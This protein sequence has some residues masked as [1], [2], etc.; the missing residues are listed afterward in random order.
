MRPGEALIA[1]SVAVVAPLFGAEDPR[2]FNLDFV[3]RYGEHRQQLTLKALHDLAGSSFDQPPAP[4]DDRYAHTVPAAGYYLT[5]L[6]RSRGY[7]AVLAKGDSDSQLA[8]IA[9]ASPRVVCISSTMLFSAASLRHLVRRVRRHL[10]GV[11]I[12]VG[13]IQVWKSYRW[14]EMSRDGLRVDDASVREQRHWSIFP[15]HRSDIEVDVFVVSPHG[16]DLLQ[17]VLRELERGESADLESIENLALPDGDGRF[18]FTRRIEER[19][20]YDHDFTRW[21]LIDE[22]PAR[23]P[24]RSSVGCPNRCAYCDFCVVYPKVHLRSRDSLAAELEL[25]RTTL[26]QRRQVAMLALVDDNAFSTPRRVREVCEVLIASRMS[27]YWM[28]FLH[29]R[30][31]NESNIELIR[32]SG[33]IMAMVGVESGDPGQLARMGRS[34]DVQRN[35]QAIELLDAAGIPVLM[36]FV[37]GFPGETRATLANTAGFLNR[38]QLQRSSSSYQVYPLQVVPMSRL[39]DPAIREHHALSGMWST[40]SHA[41]MSAGDTVAVG[42]ELFEMVVDVPYHYEDESP[43]F[44][45]RWDD[46]RRKRLFRLRHLLTRK[47]LEKSPHTALRSTLAQIADCMG[48]PQASP[49]DHFIDQLCVGDTK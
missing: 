16:G 30:H 15:C 41:T 19:P 24:I 18:A 3:V 26:R 9:R 49:P 22:L 39:G 44:N 48:H 12:I 34:Q 21:D 4:R 31:V 7:D 36:Y 46:D 37:L 2:G 23:I 20:D 5:G 43:R 8:H 38:L 28:S 25:I 10:P 14:L 11:T 27:T 29:T 6:L 42:R 1:F 40:W 33:L 45:R 35:A 47:L 17:R 13:G 32:R